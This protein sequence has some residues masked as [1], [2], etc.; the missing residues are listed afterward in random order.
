MRPR[1]FRLRLT[2]EEMDELIRAARHNAAF[3]RDAYVENVARVASLTAAISDAE[4]LQGPLFDELNRRLRGAENARLSSLQRWENA[5]A[6]YK[7]M[8]ITMN[9]GAAK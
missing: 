3:L 8:L 4:D 5:Q 2:N 1:N 9:A 6:A 7:G